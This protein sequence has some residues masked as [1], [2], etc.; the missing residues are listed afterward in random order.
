MNKDKIE[1]EVN[2]MNNSLDNHGSRI[3]RE[4]YEPLLKIFSDEYL[5]KIK[6]RIN[7]LIN[8]M[9]SLV[10][11]EK[12]TLFLIFRKGLSPKKRYQ[13]E[14]S[15]EGIFYILNSSYISIVEEYEKWV[16]E[17]EKVLLETPR[18]KIVLVKPTY[19]FKY[20]SNLK[21]ISSWIKREKETRLI[22]QKEGE[23]S[24]KLQK[25]GLLKIN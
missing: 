19:P 5:E 6:L 4:I 18:K 10:N 20:Y 13:L 9:N 22:N 23:M 2:Q 25:A 21:E 11:P 7:L 24:F 17:E 16:C 1:I 15:K 12:E 14:C 8:A 3:A